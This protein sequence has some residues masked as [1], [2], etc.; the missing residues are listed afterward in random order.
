MWKIGDEIRLIVDLP[1][2]EDASERVFPNAWT[3]ERVRERDI[4]RLFVLHPFCQFLAYENKIIGDPIYLDQAGFEGA[5][6]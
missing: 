4:G 3:H 6:A 2:N 5:F 1:Y